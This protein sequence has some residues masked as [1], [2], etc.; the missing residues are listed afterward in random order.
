MQRLIFLGLGFFFAL[1]LVVA[2]P[3][4]QA[5]FQSLYPQSE[6]HQPLHK[7]Y[8]GLENLTGKALFQA[9][10]IRTGDGFREQGYKAAKTHL[11]DVVDHQNGRVLT[12]YSEVFTRKKGSRY[13]ES[14]DENQ[15]GTSYDFVNCEHLWPQSFFKKQGPMVSDLH[16]LYPSFSKPN[17]VRGH[18]PFGKVADPRY[19][20]VAGSQ[21]GGAI[22]EPHDNVKGNVARA[23]LYFILRYHKKAIFRNTDQD[24]F[25]NQRIDQYFRW[26]QSDPPDDWERTRNER[27]EKY[28]GN[29]NP[30]IDN[31][32]LVE[33]IGPVPFQR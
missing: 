12:L 18:H 16:H 11:Y 6:I 27:I 25:W 14:G 21:Y 31:P 5:I 26:H 29:R 30:F 32:Q 4:R 3:D 20:T 13:L 1:A 28:Q 15:D 22:F 24:K 10:H 23:L 33:K 9:L 7:R 17:H 2:E 19:S 8:R